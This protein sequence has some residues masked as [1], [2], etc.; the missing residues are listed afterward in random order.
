LSSLGIFFLTYQVA[1][2][3]RLYINGGSL[4]RQPQLANTRRGGSG[5]CAVTG[6]CGGGGA[7]RESDNLGC[8]VCSGQRGLGDGGG[9]GGDGDGMLVGVQRSGGIK[10]GVEG[11]GGRWRRE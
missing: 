3:C 1:T 4:L 8:G 5:S 9:G 6:T 10:V 7:A 11:R 2:E